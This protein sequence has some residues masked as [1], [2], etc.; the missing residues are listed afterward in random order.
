MSSPL[1]TP[2]LTRDLAGGALDRLAIDDPDPQWQAFLGHLRQVRLQTDNE[3]NVLWTPEDAF[4][5]QLQAYLAQTAKE[6][7]TADGR[8][9]DSRDVMFDDKDWTGW[10]RSFFGWWRSLSPVPFKTHLAL[11][12]DP[13]PSTTQVAFFGDWGSGRYGAPVIARTIEKMAAPLGSIIHLGD[14]YYAG[15]PEE[16]EANV[17][18]V[19]PTRKDARSYLLN[20]NH[21]RYGGDIGYFA[22]LEQLNQ[23]FSYFAQ[24]NEH[25]TIVCLDSAY[26]DCS[27]AGLQV[28]WLHK[29]IAHSAGKKIIL[30]THHQPYSAFEGDGGGMVELLRPI[31]EAK[32]IHAWYWGH[33]HRCVLY[34]RHPAWG[35]MGRCVGHGGYPYFQVTADP[36][37]KTTSGLNG[38]R[39]YEFGA[40]RG[41]PGGR[42]LGD[43]NPYVESP[44]KIKYGAHGFVV[45]EL[46]GPRCIESYRRPDGEKVYEAELPL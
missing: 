14:T 11:T 34:D 7:G 36:G 20:G 25:F 37:W 29:I 33:E 12:V 46:D 6:K 23:P 21:E 16:L 26:D 3:D 18:K 27:L 9:L 35:L 24:G 45:L 38:S 43:D 1:I 13:L 2:S 44:K 31:L 5:G 42:I 30:M 8:A 4:T 41:A 28:D 40:H 22:A 17:L 10:A 32:Q 15:T 19:W 39:W